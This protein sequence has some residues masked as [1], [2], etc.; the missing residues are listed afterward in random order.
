MIGIKRDTLAIVVTFL[1]I[2]I[3]SWRFSASYFSYALIVWGTFFI[4][5]GIYSWKIGY[6]FTLEATKPFLYM[7]FGILV[8]YLLFILSALL[9]GDSRDIS[10]AFAHFSLTLPFFMT[11]WISSK[12]DVEKGV[13]WGLVIG[14]AI[15]CIIGGHQ[16]IEHPEMRI[17]ASYAHP[18]H[19]G[20]MINLMVPCIIYSAYKEKSAL[21]RVLSI[22]V[23]TAA[24]ICLLMTGSRGALMGLIGAVILG[25]GLS[26][27]LLKDQ[28]SSKVKKMGAAFMV[29]VILLGGAGAWYMQHD[30]KEVRF[31]GEREYMIEA[32][33]QM[34]EDHT[35]I[36]VGADHWKEHYYGKYHPKEG[37]EQDLSMPHNMFLY[38]LST[39][40]I[41]GALGYVLYLI[42]TGFGLAM[43]IREKKDFLLA[44]T[45]SVI[46]FSFFIQGMVDTTII[47]KIPARMYFAL[48]GV[49]AGLQVTRKS[50][51]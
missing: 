6:P 14:L 50:K 40:G 30:R 23:V 22:L 12:Y 27:W 21:Y 11:W 7:A 26:L 18:N 47:N 29:A 51:L 37:K 17:L 39:G 35:L 16:W 19:F 43:V 44:L 42:S 45:V 36:G 10:K 24:L 49:I 4:A 13:H 32:S 20:T 8:L 33:L 5:D 1:F 41:L 9:H 31:G 38:F 46:F 28:V 48:M 3:L 15:A 2:S 34:W 25:F